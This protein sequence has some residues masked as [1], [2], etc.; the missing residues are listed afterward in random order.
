MAQ[1]ATTRQISGVTGAR[2]D[3]M[4]GVSGMASI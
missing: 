4:N 2:L 1:I 3:Q